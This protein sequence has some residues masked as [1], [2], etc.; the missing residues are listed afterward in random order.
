MFTSVIRDISE[1]AL[2][3][4]EES[5]IVACPRGRR[6]AAGAGLVLAASLF[7]ASSA[8]AP[9]F[10][11][12]PGTGILTGQNFIGIVSSAAAAAV[13]GSSDVV[14]ANTAFLTQ[15]TAFVS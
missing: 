11:A 10:C 13:T 15:S 2:V 1:Q 8:Q 7:A 12:L 6:I 3:K 5:A 9:N 14:A 4:F